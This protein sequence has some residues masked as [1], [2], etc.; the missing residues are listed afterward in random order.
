MVDDKNNM[1]EKG[2]EIVRFPM[3]DD[4]HVL[5][6]DLERAN[7]R[8]RISR[9]GSLLDNI[10]G[11]HHFPLVIEQLLAETVTL[12]IILS[13]MLKYDGIFI[14]QAQGD[15]ILSRLV[16]DVT[17]TGD[18]RGSAGFN[19]DELDTLLKKN[20][21][22]T[23]KDLVGVG[24]LA[25]TVDQGEYT[26]RYQ[27][28]VELK[29]TLLESIHHYFSQSEQIGT[30][31]KMA[32]R[33]NEDGHWRAGTIMLQHTP[34]HSN[35]PQDV[36]PIAENWNRAQILLE[37]CM[38]EELL[39]VKLHDDTLLFRLFHE[40]TVRVYQP[41]SLNKGCRCTPEKLKTVLGMLSADD[42]EHAATDGK[43][44]MTCEFCNKDFLFQTEEI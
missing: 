29:D 14:L 34:D 27:G 17:S 23:L 36:K 9:L 38:D 22:P 32:V 39:D 18:V 7:L 6:F 2:P 42:R 13:S 43:I 19:R 10:L 28:I 44:T 11:P 35:I 20:P 5:T 15:G 40:E 21:T 8:G 30:A 3:P 41:H 37:T 16:S 24:Y 31:I 33:K 1:E 26:E 12:S 4:S 25:F